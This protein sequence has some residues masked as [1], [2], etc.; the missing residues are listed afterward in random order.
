MV[1]IELL[2]GTSSLGAI[3]TSFLLRN[4]LMLWAVFMEFIKCFPVNVVYVTPIVFVCKVLF[5]SLVW[6]VLFL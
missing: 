6:W 1:V 3:G 2:K 4:F 5:Q